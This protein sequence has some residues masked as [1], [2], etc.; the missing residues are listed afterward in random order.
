MKN[1]TIFARSLNPNDSNS[2]G[3]IFRS[4]FIAVIGR[5]NVGKSSLVNALVGE[6]VSIVSDKP[7]TTRNRIMGVVNGQGHQIVMVDTPGIQK[8]RNRLGSYME[9]TVKGSLADVDAVIVVLDG[10][11]GLGSRDETAIKQA[12]A[13][14][15]PVLYVINKTDRM[16]EEKQYAYR[17]AVAKQ[18]QADAIFLLSAKTGE[19]LFELRNAIVALLPQ[20]PRYFPD[21]MV[22]DKP[23][24][25]LCAEIVR[26]KALTLLRDEVPHGIGVGIEKFMERDDG[27]VE[28]HAVIYC[29]RTRHKGII[30]GKGGRMLKQIGTQAR[31]DMEMLFDTKVFLS[32][33]VK[34]REDWQDNP[35]VLKELGYR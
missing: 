6:K 12:Q 4:G 27:V 21:D 28:I 13:S 25:F 22:T 3:T 31:Q 24:S 11:S 33:Y 30:I 7:Q 5:P 34:A 2:K 19:G 1:D 35:S 26:E 16:T 15:A 32:L 18:T 17:E 8:P 23:E 14:G 29:E 20:G 9:G 10:T